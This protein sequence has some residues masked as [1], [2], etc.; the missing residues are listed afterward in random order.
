MRRGVARSRPRFYN[1]H[2]V[3]KRYKLPRWVVKAIRQAAHAYGSQ[4]RA[5]QVATELLIRQKRPIRVNRQRDGA[6][7]GMTYKLTPRTVELIEELCAKYGKRGN[8]LA[9]CAAILSK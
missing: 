1:T 3:A 4:G 6:V 2:C 7:I 8:V 5:F 9:A